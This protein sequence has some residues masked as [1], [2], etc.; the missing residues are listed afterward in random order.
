MST[1]F[2][3]WFKWIMELIDP[4]LTAHFYAFIS[5]DDVC[6]HHGVEGKNL[7]FDNRRLITEI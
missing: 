1:F 7:I 2:R 3:N 6:V 5:V 4:L